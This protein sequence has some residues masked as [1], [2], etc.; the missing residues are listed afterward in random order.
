L[1]VAPQ[2]RKRVGIADLPG[3]VT[4][5]TVAGIMRPLLV[6]VVSVAVAVG[7]AC[8]SS[9]AFA[10]VGAPVEP[11]PPTT[12]EPPPADA[13]APEGEPPEADT[14]EVEPPLDT[15]EVEPPL[16]TDEEPL[17]TELDTEIDGTLDREEFDDFDD[18]ISVRDSPEAKVARRW[19]TA[20]IA[21]TITGGVLV[22][23]AIAM[24]MTDPCTFAAGNSCFRDARDRAAVTLGAP[25]GLLLLGGVTMTIVGSL[26]RRRLWYGLA[27]APAPNGI[28]VSGRF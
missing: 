15:D 1:T 20:G 16:D 4:S 8:P 14:D 10:A 27:I 23:G 18:Y 12:A 11:E 28:V 21:A 6:R 25:G 24:G 13:E 7:L 22:G 9:V 5:F 3:P 2:R 17:D 19:L 26:Q